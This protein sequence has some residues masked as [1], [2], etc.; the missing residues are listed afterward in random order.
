MLRRTHALAS[1]ALALPLLASTD[2]GATA[3]RT[4]VA[5]YG[6]STNTA[7]NCSI[8]KPC[9]GFGEA[10]GVTNAGG[11]VIVLD[12]AGYGPVTITKSVSIIAPAGI[13]G[14]ISVFAGDGVTINMPA[15]T[16]KVVLQGLTINNQ[17]SGTNG[18]NFTGAGRLEVTRTHVSGFNEFPDSGLRFSPA[19]GGGSLHAVDL[20]VIGNYRGIS[21]LGGDTPAAAPS[22]AL[23]R[24][25]ASANHT[26][27]AVQD[28]VTIV[29]VNSAI[30][31]NSEGLLGVSTGQY[32]VST[33]DARTLCRVGQRIGRDSSRPRDTLPHDI[34]I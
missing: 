11:E 34:R 5:S 10:I 13:Y 4:F 29:I 22:V 25:E 14:G 26:G 33:P 16:D 12:S 1:I 15:A 18:I 31:Q 6:L 30:T 20:T 23:E 9:R 32:Y 17:G 21:I 24:I 2:A 28:F 19:A 3:Q 7:F 27:I 8:T